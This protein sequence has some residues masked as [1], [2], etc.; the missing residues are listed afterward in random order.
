MKLLSLDYLFEVLSTIDLD[1]GYYINNDNIS[2]TR[3]LLELLFKFPAI[4][5]LVILWYN[6]RSRNQSLGVLEKVVYKILEVLNALAYEYF[7]HTQKK[8]R[9]GKPY[10]DRSEITQFKKLLNELDELLLKELGVSKHTDNYLPG[11][12]VLILMEFRSTLARAAYEDHVKLTDAIKLENGSLKQELSK[13]HTEFDRVL[14]PVFE[15]TKQGDKNNTYT[16]R[17]PLVIECHEF[18]DEFI[19]NIRIDMKNQ[20]IAENNLDLKLFDAKSKPTLLTVKVLNTP[21]LMMIWL[22]GDTSLES[23]KVFEFSLSEFWDEKSEV[24]AKYQL[25][26]VLS[27]NKNERSF[28]IITKNNEKWVG[29]MNG[30][31]VRNT[32]NPL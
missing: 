8:Y 21:S 16:L 28:E 10:Y 20:I 23:E 32:P 24:D 17:K 13:Y 3:E 29:L 1:T 18:N 19:T 12:L 9:A 27:Y 7:K 11:A 2:Q 26:G 5:H 14:N 25:I 31:E 22:T 15:F 30:E 6:R 4:S